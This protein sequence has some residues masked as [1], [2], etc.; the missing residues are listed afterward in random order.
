MVF[1]NCN[2]S[3]KT[4]KDRALKAALEEWEEREE[5]EKSEEDDRD[6]QS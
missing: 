4:L 2:L 1:N 3:H 5:R 6:K